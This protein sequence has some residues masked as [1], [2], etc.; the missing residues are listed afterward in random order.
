[1]SNL[2]NVPLGCSVFQ[3]VSSVLAERNPFKTKIVLPNKRSCRALVKYMQQH[4]DCSFIPSI[5][6]VEELISVQVDMKKMFD[7]I[8]TLF[9][10]YNISFDILYNLT[11]N[12]SDFIRELILNQVDYKLLHR[13]IPDNL[14][15][16]WQLERKILSAIG[17]II[18]EEQHKYENRWREIRKLVQTHTIMCAGIGHANNAVVQLIKEVSNSANGIIF[19]RG[20]EDKSCVNHCINKKLQSLCAQKVQHLASQKNAQILDGFV[21]KNSTEEAFAAAALTREALEQDKSILIIA[22][23]PDMTQKIQSELLRWNIVADTSLGKNLGQTPEGILV[24]Q[25][26]DA[27]T[28]NYQ[29]S[30]VI[31]LLKMSSVAPVEIFQLELWLRKRSLGSKNFFKAFEDLIKKNENAQEDFPQL[32]SL[33]R[34]LKNNLPTREIY[35]ISEWTGIVLNIAKIVSE[36]LCTSFENDQPKIEIDA[37]LTAQEFAAFFKKIISETAVRN[38][39]GHT[40]NVAI[41]GAIEAQLLDADVVIL[42]GLNEKQWTASSDRHW[43]SKHMMENFRIP[44][45]REKNLFLESIF[46]HFLHQKEVFLLRSTI[47][48]G[49]QQCMYRPLNKLSNPE[50]KTYPLV[51]IFE[52]SIPLSKQVFEKPMVA[53]I[54][55]EFYVSDIDLLQKNPYAFFAK[56]ILNLREQNDIDEFR[57]L[58]GNFWH[59]FLEKFIS[60]KCYTLEKAQEIFQRMMQKYEFDAVDFYGLK[61]FKFNEL[62]EKIIENM[63]NATTQY[64]VEID[65]E[66]PLKINK[67]LTIKLK[68]R[69]DRIDLLNGKISMVDYKT[70]ELPSK[71][72]IQE[73]R[74]LQLIIEAIIAR[75]NGFGLNIHTVE[76]TNFWHLKNSAHR[77]VL[78]IAENVAEVE[79]MC[80]IATKTIQ[81]LIVKYFMDCAGYNLSIHDPHNQ[82]Y[83]H[84]AR[85][86]E[87]RYE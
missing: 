49:K 5:V 8:S 42:T 37:E 31:S 25:I 33:I 7:R 50:W 32:V 75:A 77:F 73:G 69:A 16:N 63:P 78:P 12:T 14:T 76:S 58:V 38:P 59:K 9:R 86:K 24:L 55:K 27:I 61:F 47:E 44:T 60:Q 19:L 40:K 48:N 68:C 10:G 72:S 29:N 34:K 1:M 21:F 70:G 43:F 87:W 52:K 57:N 56:K 64:Y 51:E 65:G 53:P 39:L 18:S 22:Q 3:E 6:A 80:E 36:E 54:P 30:D 4:L 41:L 45:K 79:E 20:M 17:A 13:S 81:E 85:M 23:T 11:V 62:L 46:E 83:Q 66:C 74:N 82:A 15:E 26:L 28:N 35:S 84:L 2:F 67:D 71:K